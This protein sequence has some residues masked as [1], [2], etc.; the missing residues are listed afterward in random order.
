ME[1]TQWV[2]ELL[3]RY[4]ESTCVLILVVME[5]TQWETEQILV[6]RK[7][8]VLILVVMEYTQWDVLETVGKGV[9]GDVLILVVMEYTQW[10]QQA[11]CL[12]VN[13]LS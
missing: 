2:Y 13:H 10:E 5:Y 8:W 12:Q 6:L 11:C 7:S 9:A 3:W 4:S 1:Y